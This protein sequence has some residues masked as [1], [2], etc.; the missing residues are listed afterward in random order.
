MAAINKGGLVNHSYPVK[1]TLFFKIQGDPDS[2]QRTSAAVRDIVQ[3]HGSSQFEFAATDQ[4]ADTLWEN[5]KY[6]LHSTIALEPNVKCWTTDVW[7]VLS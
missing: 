4:E 1:D 2:I 6:A 5:R 7:Y 3:R